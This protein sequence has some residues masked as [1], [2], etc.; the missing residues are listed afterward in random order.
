MGTQKVV[1]DCG[2]RVIHFCPD[3]RP[4]FEF[5]GSRGETSIPLISSLEVTKL[6]NEGCQAFLAAV[7]DT[8]IGEPKLENIPVMFEF[9]DVF[10]QELSG[11]PPE[12]EI[13]FVIELAPRTEPILKAPYRM[14]LSKLKELKV[15]MQELLDNGFI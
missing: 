8:T 5:M 7:V 4:E 10:P 11:L 3:G 6:L 15:Q 2:S 14:S 1:I 12:R 13:E 9:S